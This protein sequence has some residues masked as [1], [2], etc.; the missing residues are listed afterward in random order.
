M[1]G[2]VLQGELAVATAEEREES[3]QVEQE[4]DH[5]AEILPDQSRE[6]NHLAAGRTFGEGQAGEGSDRW[7][8]RTAEASAEQGRSI[9]RLLRLVS[10]LSED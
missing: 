9:G 10:R 1:Q 5:R 6:I 3:Q 8:E 2:E 4:G 7:A